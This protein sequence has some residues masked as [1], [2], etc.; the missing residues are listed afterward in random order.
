MICSFPPLADKHSRIL[1][2]GTM[3]GV[4][5]L[6]KQQYYAHP[7]NAFW[8]I[9]FSIFAEL[10]VPPDFESRKQLLI[11]NGIALWDVLETCEREGSLDTNIKNSVPNKIPELLAENP[12]IKAIFF[13][14]KE[15]HRLFTKAFGNTI[16]LPQFVM[17]STSPA[18]TMKFEEKLL[19]WKS[20]LV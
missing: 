9:M 19:K 14:G 2:L 10:P 16:P 20:L 3:P 5:S 8:K 17:P 4:Q 18:N 11:D 13:N 15:S 1:I 6:Q 7:Q 12:N